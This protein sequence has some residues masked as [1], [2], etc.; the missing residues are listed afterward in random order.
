[1]VIAFLLFVEVVHDIAHI[2]NSGHRIH[3][4]QPIQR[5]VR[6]RGLV[7][8]VLV[9]QNALLFAWSDFLMRMLNAAI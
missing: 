1:M 9:E 4:V 2:I 3:K 6:L 7:G 5:Q 8:E